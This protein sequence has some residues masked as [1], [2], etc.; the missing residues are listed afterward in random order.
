MAASPAPYCAIREFQSNCA[1]YEVR[2]YLSD[3]SAPGRT[4][5][6]VRSKIYY[7]LARAGIKLSIPARSVVV[8]EDADA[9]VEKSLKAEQARRLDALRGVDVFQALTEGERGILAGLLKPTPFAAGETITRQGSVADW[10]YIVYSGSV[11]V[12]L[13]S[14]EAGAY[15]AVKTLG[16]GDF[17]GE[18]GLFTG[19][20]RSATAVAAGNVGCY[21]LDREGFRGILASRPEIA[22]SLALTLARR[23]GELAEAREKLA[24]ESAEKG[25]VKEQQHLLSKIKDFFKL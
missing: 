22:Q 13:Y 4:D 1:V 9:A 25:L 8:N 7:A 18:M 16:P 6:N 14:G 3:L 23:R 12:R 15:R 2:Y 20:P 21:R 17:L 24:G 10:I 5:S 19:E 11:E